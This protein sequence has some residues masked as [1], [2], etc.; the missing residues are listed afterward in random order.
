MYIVARS[1][2]NKLSSLSQQ[3]DSFSQTYGKQ[4]IFYARWHFCLKTKILTKND[5]NFR[6]VIIGVYID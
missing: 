1:A 3:L 6:T 4:I 5:L 2:G